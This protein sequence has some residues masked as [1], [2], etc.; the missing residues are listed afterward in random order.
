[1]KYVKQF[2][3]ILLISFVGEILSY[4]IPMPIPASIYGIV[5]L[6]LGLVTGLIPLDSVKDVG[7]FLLEIMPIMFIPAGVGLMEAAGLVID[8]WLYYT[9][10]MVITTV[11]VMGISGRVTQFF[12]RKRMKKNE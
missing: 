4:L 10:V 9:L 8:S 1:M 12:V 7:K 2:T 11:V 3:I 6:F 5:I